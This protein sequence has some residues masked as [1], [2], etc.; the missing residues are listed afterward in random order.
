VTRQITLSV[1][2]PKAFGHPLTW[3]GVALS[4]A[5]PGFGL[6][7]FYSFVLH[8]RLALGRWPNFGE[9]LPTPLL[10]FHF[11]CI[12]RFGQ[13]LFAS[14]YVAWVL[15]IGSLCFRRWRH[16]AI[17]VIVYGA[18]AAIAIGIAALAPGPFLNW[19]L[20]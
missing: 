16:I 19:F 10:S 1:E 5:L 8:L 9:A 11:E 20:D 17:Y 13:V 12:R 15:L 6:L 7:L 2:A 3:K 18:F 14:V 4:A